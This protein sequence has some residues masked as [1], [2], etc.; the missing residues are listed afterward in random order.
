MRKVITYGTF[1]LFHKGHYNILKLA[2]EQ[3]DFLI[4]GV[5]SETYDI[6]RGKLSVHDDLNTRIN[7]VKATGF[8]D[9]VI[10]EEYQGQKIRDIQKYGVDVFV[11]GSDWAGMFEN[12][13]PYCQVVYLERTKNISST[14]IREQDHAMKIGILTDDMDDASFVEEVKYVSGFHVQSVYAPDGDLADAFCKKYGLA[15]AKSDLKDFL[16]TL[17][18][19]YVKSRQDHRYDQV[20]AAIAAGVHVIAEIPMGMT[21]EEVKELLELAN[22]KKVL[23][24]ENIRTAYLRGFNQLAWM[25]QSNHI[26]GDIY[27]IR[28][29]SDEALPNGQILTHAFYMISKLLGLSPQKMQ[30]DICIRDEEGTLQYEVVNL[31]YPRALAS[32]EI[33]RNLHEDGRME[34]IGSTG[35][36][37]VP[38]DWWNTR[39]YKHISNQ[40]EIKR[41]SFNFEGNGLRYI[42]QELSIVLRNH[43]YDNPRLTKEES[44]GIYEKILQLH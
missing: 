43:L 34:I 24:F 3:V 9:M 21:P 31:K 44:V 5:T 19:V 37:V 40:G 12:L 1:D 41:Y 7:N 4:V 10:I 13:R 35:H 14:Q 29:I 23:L 30:K 16:S 25:I 20:K 39:Y 2:K 6:E 11:I 18:L 33:N 26:I 38:N 22:E 27:N 28:C 15:E 17:Q 32:I 42:L 8:A 36:I